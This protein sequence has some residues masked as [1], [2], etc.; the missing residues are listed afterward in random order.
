M[1]RSLVAAGAA[2]VILMASL[3]CGGGTA[4]DLTRNVPAATAEQGPPTPLAKRPYRTATP[5]PSEQW[6]WPTVTPSPGDATLTPD[7]VRT[8]IAPTEGPSNTGKGTP[9]SG[10]TGNSEPGETEVAKPTQPSPAIPTRQTHAPLPTL[11]VPGVAGSWGRPTAEPESGLPP[12]EAAESAES[13]IQTL[14]PEETDCL[15]AAVPRATGQASLELV[16]QVAAC[17]TTESALKFFLAPATSAAG[18]LSQRTSDCVRAR[19]L[20]TEEVGRLANSATGN[21]DRGLAAAAYML[22]ADC[23]DAEEYE[24]SAE[25]MGLAP[26]EQGDIRCTLAKMG[27]TDK[28]TEGVWR[29]QAPA[30]EEWR[31]AMTLCERGQERE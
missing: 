20:P 6:G 19:L 24:S 29:G 2:T 25:A 10:A 1:T 30:T 4:E 26:A 7:E 15:L 18:G 22:A 13:L 31:I 9:G 17:L 11:I 23:M 14:S 3:A 16:D 5:D 28:V 8:L 27:G 21:T 12:L